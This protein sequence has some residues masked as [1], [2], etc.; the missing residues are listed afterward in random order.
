MIITDGTVLLM[1]TKL[2]EMLTVRSVKSIQTILTLQYSTI[3]L[4]NIKDNFL[5]TVFVFSYR[6]KLFNAV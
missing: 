3:L 1:T 2:T 5:E 4:K 6:H